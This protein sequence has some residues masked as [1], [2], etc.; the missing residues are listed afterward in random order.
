MPKQVLINMIF[1]FWSSQE[2]RCA[3]GGDF[4]FVDI[5][6]PHFWI[7]N[8][9]QFCLFLFGYADM[10]VFGL[11]PMSDPLHLVRLEFRLV[12]LILLTLIHICIF[13][14]VHVECLAMDTDIAQSHHICHSWL[15]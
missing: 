6:P 14:I 2:S 9:L 10:H 1:I 8:F 12:L 5:C 4:C 13:Y 3:T 11:K 7:L 15:I